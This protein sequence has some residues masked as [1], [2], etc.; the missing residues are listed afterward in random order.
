MRWECVVAPAYYTAT[1]H[2]SHAAALEAQGAPGEINGGGMMHVVIFIKNSNALYSTCE[3]LP[4]K[5][6]I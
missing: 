5:V 1:T 6:F 2:S 4:D 3:C